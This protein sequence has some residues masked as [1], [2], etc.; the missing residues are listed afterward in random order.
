MDGQK[1]RFWT[2][3]VADERFRDAVI[4][5]PLRALS[6]VTDVEV[7]AEQVCQLEEMSRDERA[8]LVREIIRETFLMNA[9][10]RYG[11]VAVEGPDA[12]PPRDETDS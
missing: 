5:D 4:D 10:A 3:V 1:T 7:S 11:P 6:D 2:R 9:I 8:E 12:L